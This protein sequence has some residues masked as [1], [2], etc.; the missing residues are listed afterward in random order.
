M[1]KSLVP[2]LWIFE[3]KAAG[4]FFPFS[5]NKIDLWNTS[6]TFKFSTHFLLSCLAYRRNNVNTLITYTIIFYR[7]ST[8]DTWE[9][10]K[11]M[12]SMSELFNT[13]RK[14]LFQLQSLELSSPKKQVQFYS[15]TTRKESR[16]TKYYKSN[17]RILCFAC[18]LCYSNN[19][20]I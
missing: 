2:A 5:L 9:I 1:K 17:S 14:S 8:T 15:K 18:F 3:R 16:K 10:I 11:K 13:L 12:S 20:V 7:F 4:Y 19:F 6:D